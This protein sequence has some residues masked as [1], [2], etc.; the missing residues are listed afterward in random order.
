MK[1]QTHP[2]QNPFHARPNRGK[3]LLAAF[4]MLL[5]ARIALAQPV[6]NSVYP[7][8]L[9]ERAGDH[10][11]FTVQASGTGTLSYQWYKDGSLLAGQTGASIV[12]TNIQTGDGGDYGATVQDSTS[13][14]AS[15]FATLNVTTN[16]LPVA[17]SNLVIVRLGD[18]AQNLS[19]ATGNTIYLD[20]YSTNGNYISTIQIPDNLP[21]LPYGVG[22]NKTVY[23]SS[24]LIL[25]GAG[26]DSINQGVLTLSADGQSLTIGGYQLAYPFTGADVTAGGATLVRGIYT[27]NGFGYYSLAYTNYGLY[28]GGNHTLRSAFTLD[29]TNFWTTGQAGSVSGLKYVNK[30]VA[31]YANG[32]GVPNVTASTT[33][34]RVVQVAN[35]NLIFSDAA[36]GTHGI[37]AYSGLPEPAAGGTATGGTVVIS[38]GGQPNDF[39]ISPDGNTVY[40]ADSQSFQGSGVEAGGIQRW[41]YG[42][43]GYAWSYT[44]PTTATNG[45][46]NLVA[47][48][49]PDVGTWGPGITGAVIYATPSTTTNN[50]VVSIA[51]TGSGSTAAT[52]VAGGPR[53]VF[54]GLRFGPTVVESVSISGQPQS[55][56]VSV[57]NTAVF[58]VA[59]LGTPPFFYQWQ[60][61]SANI[62][63]ATQQTLTLTNVQIANSGNYSVLVSN[64][65]SLEASSSAF[66]T[67]N[68]GPP[69]ITANPQSWVEAAGDHTAFSVKASGATP[70]NY[71]WFYN[72]APVPGGTNSSLVL[73]NVQLANQ[74]SYYVTLTNAVGWTNTSP[75]TL[76]VT[77][78]PRPL[79]SNNLVVARVGDGS[80]T[81]SAATGNT[82]YIDQYSTNGTYVSSIQI[83]DEG[84]GLPYGYGA[85]ANSSS[86]LNLP[87]G[88]N[89]ILV[90]GAGSDAPYEALLTL[91][92][93]EASINFA[94]YLQAY[95]YNGGD[96]SYIGQTAAG[97][98]T[99]NWRGIGGVSA[100]GYYTLDYTN[101][102]LFSGGSHQIHSA[103]TLEGV[104]FWSA[105]EAQNDGVKFVSTADSS[106]ANGVG[107]PQIVSSGP[108]PRVVQVINGNLVFSDASATPPGIY[109]AENGGT[110]ALGK[111]GSTNSVLL[112]N[113]GGSPVD[114]VASPDKRTIYISD[115]RAFTGANSQG[116]GIQR[117]DYNGSGYSYS[118]T[119]STGTNAVGALGLTAYFLPATTSWGS[120][121]T[122]ATLFATTAEQPNNRLISV[123]DNGSGS[124]PSTL[125][126]NGANQR[127]AGIRFGPSVV[128]PGIYTNPQP[129]SAFSDRA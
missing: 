50:V 97:N 73:T 119:L 3:Q 38:E 104:N 25:P 6:I 24:S 84:A 61:N 58:S 1:K 109:A 94:G 71:Q 62:A 123:V 110:P 37:W 75:A 87:P 28:N 115:D 113:E 129:A 31:T 101:S 34:P 79:S 122:G 99:N 88:S 14:Y 32:S 26:G 19:G 51:D 11:A 120:G 83:P 13:A 16:Y 105:G 74:G 128:V 111:N 41:D 47:Y 46:Q 54:R 20:Q 7:P 106:Y 69:V 80:Q 15:N 85:G 23:G 124:T 44:L 86:S 78:S 22:T 95:P 2:T 127:F 45:A 93:D 59:T 21:G 43:S 52:F 72:G 42:V 117:W 5:A 8:Q 4:S 121:V 98:S 126:V 30:T 118:Y 70:I 10:V 65:S 76:T 90:A 18:G 107:V 56:A 68:L 60:F 125:A 57:G 103:V 114:F 81:L 100:Y 91:S 40:I 27:I 12:L 64:L 9:N 108:G 49:P 35:G 63:G 92:A 33:G 116:G 17:S 96:V 89:P 77:S 112:L 39:A 53:Q 36:A 82:I 29:G 48:F 102:G 67:V 66:L 55:Q